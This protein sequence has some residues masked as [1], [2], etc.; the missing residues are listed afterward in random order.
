MHRNYFKF[1]AA[2]ALFCIF[3]VVLFM[4][5]ERLTKS[6]PTH[7]QF[8]PRA[9]AP[10]PSYI[11][12]VGI[13]EANGGN[14]YIGSPVNRVVDKVEVAVGQKV[15]KGDVLFR[16]EA[17]DLD[18]DLVSRCINYQN[19]LVSLKKLISL[20]RKEDVLSAEAQLRA[21]QVE[22]D[23]AK[24]QFQRVDGL[25]KS[26]AMS[27]EEIAR[28]QFAFEDAAAKYQQAEADLDKIQ[29]GAWPPDVEIARLQVKQSKAMVQRAK[30]DLKRTIIRSPIDGTVLQIKIHE[31]EFPPSDS[32]RTPPMIV[33]NTDPMNLRV[34]I[35]QFDA[36]YFNPEAK[37]I[38]YLQGNSEVSFPLKFVQ[39]EPYFVTKQ[40]LNNDITEKVDT[41]VLQA[42]YSFEE[43][44]KRVYVGQQMDVFIETQF[45]PKE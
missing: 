9:L 20:P 3:I 41:R 19:A 21:A 24:S 15:K 26:G 32:L 2:L 11:S 33:G 28:R 1:L 18:A 42:I 44:E 35:N 27:D 38:A 10:F 40:N 8:A 34:S 4:W 16:L 43:E 17:H 31:G 36:S 12:A 14:I 23:Q 25:Q 5:N 6:P 7:T 13:V 37:A 45:T 22:L 30:A 29:A 39:L